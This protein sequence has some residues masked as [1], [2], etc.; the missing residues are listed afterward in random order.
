MPQKSLLPATATEEAR[1]NES[2]LE[3]EQRI[4]IVTKYLP[5]DIY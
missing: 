5:Q 2:N 3:E 1:I 4:C